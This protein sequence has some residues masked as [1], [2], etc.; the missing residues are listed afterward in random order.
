M[1]ALTVFRRG[2]YIADT[3]RRPRVREQR[4]PPMPPS[5]AFRGLD[6]LAL[7]AYLDRL[8]H[9]RRVLWIGDAASGAPDRAARVAST[10]LVADPDFV[11]DRVE[12]RNL[13]V[14]HLADGAALPS[15]PHDVIVV[16]DLAT[17]GLGT[18][19]RVRQLAAVLAPGGVLVAASSNGEATAR[20][21]RAPEGPSLAYEAL[22][23]LLAQ[24]F[25]AVR[26][27]GQAPFAGYTVADFSAEGEPAVVFD[28]SLLGD[29][30]ET[31][32]RFVALCGAADVVLDAFAVVQLPAQAVL[33]AG[34]A[35]SDASG[36]ADARATALAAEL[37]AAR[38][39][40]DA[41]N[42]HAEELEATLAQRTA[43]LAELDGELERLRLELGA[44]RDE[45]E[46]RVAALRIARDELE[47]LRAAPVALPADHARLEELL[48]E[49][50]R[51]LRARDEELA[52][53]AT[54]FRDLVEELGALREGRLID[55]S[56]AAVDAERRAS[57]AAQ[58]VVTLEAQ[59][60]AVRAERE[61][62][63]QR[64]LQAEAERTEAAFRVD[65]A[66]GRLA[67]ISERSDRADAERTRREAELSGFVRG[68]R[69]RAAELEEMRGQAEARLAIGRL[70][71][72]EKSSQIKGLERSVEEL[73]DQL[74]LQLVRASSAGQQPAS[75]VDAAAL[76]VL[77]AERDGLRARLEDREA[78]LAARPAPSPSDPTLLTRFE[79][80]NARATS[81][82][83]RLEESGTHASSLTARLA[84]AEAA[85]ESER[86]RVA[87]LTARVT[88]REAAIRAR[89]ADVETGLRAQ[90]ASLARVDGLEAES[91]RLAAALDEA[92][93][94]L[95]SLGAN[96]ETA[97]RD[98][99]RATLSGT[100]DAPTDGAHDG[101]ELVA[102][103]H[104]LDG[105]QHELRDR[106]LLLRSLSEQLRER[107]E[108]LRTL[109]IRSASDAA[110]PAG[111]S[112][113]TRRLEEELRARESELAQSQS[114]VRTAD[115]ELATARDAVAASRMGLEELLAAATT[116]GDATAADR[117]GALLR[118]LSRV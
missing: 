29:A 38:E 8:F 18:A 35:A 57:E 94:C 113:E 36:A 42:V 115:R 90:Q 56:S 92:R 20:F 24:S 73:R 112:A 95:V 85:I 28:G 109:S 100:L 69:A 23:E 12:R 102:L 110:A 63:V 65:E 68:L 37:R 108:R 5:E 55:E 16:G 14:I 84:I 71:V 39:Q 48:R 50:G 49:R 26:M 79:E 3:P 10:V 87:D 89:E 78:A 19:Q 15:G 13:R 64:A 33:A 46:T 40:V 17:V 116:R 60:L 91:R 97:G 21:R 66:L 2:G 77:R 117:I 81:L 61:R 6:D 25:P 107:D 106:E 70:E 111:T 105:L 67:E 51:E 74:E 27:L 101:A 83:A 31:A 114:K 75:S 99:T 82:A 45:S 54:L 58:R 80:A 43:A 118:A 88:E 9:G 34:R 52:R 11:G 4:P 62:A 53:R 7:S 44:A 59:L 47:K 98:G 22:Y 32:E 103:R 30:S 93:A 1:I 41:G 86:Q 104:Q 72:S 96:L 76:D